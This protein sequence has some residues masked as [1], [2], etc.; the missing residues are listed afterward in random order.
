MTKV[1]FLMTHKIT[2]K[3]ISITTKLIIPEALEVEINTN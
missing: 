1:L 2:I 3:L